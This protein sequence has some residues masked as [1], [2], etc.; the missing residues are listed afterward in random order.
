MKQATAYWD[1][2]SQ[3]TWDLV[4]EEKQNKFE[5]LSFDFDPLVNLN[6]R[7]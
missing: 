2:S 1:Q 6:E 5:G 3:K 7:S 4:Q